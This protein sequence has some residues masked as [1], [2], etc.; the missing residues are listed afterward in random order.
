MLASTFGRGVGTNR[1][2][3]EKVETVELK[4]EKPKRPELWESVLESVRNAIVMGEMAPGTR[5]VE[6]ELS[7]TMGVSRLPV[8]QAISRLE[9]EGLVVRY[10]NR[11]AYV[12]EFTAED[13]HEIYELRRLLECHAVGLACSRWSDEAEQSLAQL[14]AELEALVLNENVRATAEPDIT[15]HRALFDVAQSPR[16]QTM[17][18][19]LVAPVQALLTFR[20]RR[21]GYHSSQ[22]LPKDHLRILDALRKQDTEAAQAA[23]LQHLTNGEASVLKLVIGGDE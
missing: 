16:L 23:V 10:R 13:V 6:S 4:L 11:G 19:V 3:W 5:L 2:C 17:W 22:G 20:N 7:A 15:F 9:Q 18:E 12:I 8:R 1:L 21:L 14:V